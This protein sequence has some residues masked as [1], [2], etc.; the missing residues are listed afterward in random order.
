MSVRVG[1]LVRPQC[2]R[3]V[4]IRSLVPPQCDRPVIVHSASTRVQCR[5]IRCLTAPSLSIIVKLARYM[6]LPEFNN[7][8]V[9][10]IHIRSPGGLLRP[11]T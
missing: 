9:N 8:T 5:A 11:G 6:T 10:G 4:I 7:I 3:P 2:E 1:S